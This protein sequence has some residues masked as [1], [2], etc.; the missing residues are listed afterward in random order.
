MKSFPKHPDPAADEQAALWA[1]KLDGSLMS[2]TDRS[3]LD[4]WLSAR[5][6]HRALL[7]RYC[8]FSADLEQQMPLIEGIK[9]LSAGARI[10]PATAQPSPWLRW[11]MMAGAVLTAAAAVALGFWLIQPKQQFKNIATPAA[12]RQ[13]LTLVDGTQIELNAQTSLQIE[14]NGQD[15]RVRLASGEAFFA[16][17]KDPSRPFTV[18]TPTGSVR[19]TGTKFDVRTETAGVLEVTVLEGSVKTNPGE[20]TGQSTASVMLKAGDHLVASPGGLE[21]Q[22]LSDTD[23]KDT[24]AWRQGQIVFKG[25]PLRDVLAKFSRY[26]GRGITATDDAAEISVGARFSLD[27]LDGFFDALETEFPVKVTRNANGTV[28]VSRRSDP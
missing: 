22:K 13:T 11:P 15:R 2:A 4:E 5:P 17:H 16:V 27:D 25:V 26:H 12:Q 20:L 7:S 8:Q 9:E 10:T 23:L 3:A 1:A 18:E 14:I 6:D 21:R 24:L 19:V 28:R